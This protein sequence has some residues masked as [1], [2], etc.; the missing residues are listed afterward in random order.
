[1]AVGGE[2]GGLIGSHW[3]NGEPYP[4][5]SDVR[6][7]FL[8]LSG[9]HDR[10][11]VVRAVLESICM[12]HRMSVERLAAAGRLPDAP[13]RV[14]GGGATSPVWMQIMADVLGHEV[15]TPRDPRYVGVMG[16]FYC[17]LVGLGL[18]P[19]YD[20]AAAQ[21]TQQGRVFSPR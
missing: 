4:I 12:T 9:D 21:F 14:V 10:R 11:H 5:G 18:F 7:I 1:D 13:L 20:A 3:L 16:A 8:G 17:A 19:D 15:E 2:M 6:A